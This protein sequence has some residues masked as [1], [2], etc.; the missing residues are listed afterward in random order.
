VS[1]FRFCSYQWRKII[2]YFNGWFLSLKKKKTSHTTAMGKGVGMADMFNTVL[3][4]CRQMPNH[5]INA[6]LLV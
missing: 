4:S 2:K 3:A 5:K 6:G 1:F